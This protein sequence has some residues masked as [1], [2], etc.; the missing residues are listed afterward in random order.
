MKIL[1]IV[2]PLLFTAAAFAQAPA[3]PP[4]S[5]PATRADILRLFRVM[6]TE[7][8]VRPIIDQVMA[9]S[10]ALSRD[11][12]KRRHPTISQADLDRMDKL[13]ANVARN[14]PV[15]ELIQDMVPVYQKHLSKT[16][17]NAMIAFYTAPTGK[18][19]LDEMPAISAESIQ[20]VYPRLQHTIDRLLQEAEAEMEVEAAP[21]PAQQSQDDKK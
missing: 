17:V 13:T 7:Q 1:R 14:F 19:L 4:P 2:L 15:Q 9:Q 11:E 18:K 3:P 6:N 12:I 8:Q 10:R 20:A 16:D 5:T 21:A